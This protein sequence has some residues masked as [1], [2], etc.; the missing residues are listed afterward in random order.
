[1]KSHSANTDSRQDVS[2]KATLPSI[3]PGV[4]VVHEDRLMRIMIK[5]GLE[6]HGFQVW[7]ASSTSEAARLYQRNRN[8]IAVVILNHAITEIEDHPALGTRKNV[9]VQVPVCFLT[10]QTTSTVQRNSEA[11]SQTPLLSE[12][13]D[14]EEVLRVVRLLSQKAVNTLRTN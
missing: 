11:P 4:L 3:L 12:P 7:S 1:M 5:L 14:M 6:R 13:F 10:D 9:L 8:R 2:A